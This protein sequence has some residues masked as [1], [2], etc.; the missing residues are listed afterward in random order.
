[1]SSFRRA[2]T[3]CH[4]ASPQAFTGAV[5]FHNSVPAAVM[6][7]IMRGER[8]PRP[9]HPALTDEL[10]A[11]TRRCWDQIPHLRPEIS[12]VL[13]LLNGMWVLLPFLRQCIRGPR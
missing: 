11:L 12:Q 10:W 5:P 13:N 1:M 7:A 4:V 9:T 2:L 8:P 3:H 6:L